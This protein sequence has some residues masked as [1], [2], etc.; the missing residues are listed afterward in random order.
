MKKM[1]FGIF[2]ADYKCFSIAILWADL[3]VLNPD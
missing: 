3:F 1:P 2:T